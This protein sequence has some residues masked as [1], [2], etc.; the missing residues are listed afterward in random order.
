M[1]LPKKDGHT[2]TP[3]SHQNSDEVFDAYIE[4]AM[5]LGFETYTITEHAPL[6]S[7]LSLPG[8]YA[9]V[10][11]EDIVQVKRETARLIKKYKQQITITKG[12]EV[13]YLANNEVNMR[14]FLRDNQTWLDEIVLAVHFIP[15]DVGELR[16]I[17][18]T[19]EYV[20]AH[21]SNLLADPQKFYQRYFQTVAQSV[22]AVIGLDMPVRIGHLGLVK[23][24]QKVLNLPDYSDEIY[25]QIGDILQMIQAR[26]YQLEFN[27]A[28]LSEPENGEAYPDNDII[29]AAQDMGIPIIYGSDA[30]RVHDIGRH[31]DLLKEVLK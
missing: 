21:F 30:H 24:F 22:E 13:D 5:T 26:G 1:M 12:F 29:T 15:D 10:T 3:F 9:V 6:L 14:R 16:P 20:S 8:D 17:D 2:H 23:K 27:A 7:G 11:D 4:R 28:G 25:R 31:F 19:A 18:Y